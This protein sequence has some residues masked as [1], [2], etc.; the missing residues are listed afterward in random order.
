MD[1]DVSRRVAVIV[2]HPDDEVLWAGGLLLNHPEWS[3]FVAVLT[4]SEDPDRAPRFHRV[5]QR[6]GAAGA[7]GDLDDGPG[8]RP[9]SN[10]ILSEAILALLPERD[11]DIIL[12]HSL[13]GEYTRHRRH[14]ETSR[15]VW[16]LCSQGLLTTRSLCLFA[17]ED[18]QGTY[19]PRA[20]EQATLRLPL[21]DR[22]WREKRNLLTEVYGLA[23]TSW[24]ARTTPREE[25]F[26]C[27]DTPGLAQAAF[28]G[29]AAL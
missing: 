23:E 1:A 13:R 12:T 5:R 24:E 8:Q 2:A 26:R 4:R 15:A 7:M 27:L 11:Y 14:E 29:G 18:G 20:D 28:G 9:L 17:Y 25:A 3:T 22:I 6:L 21:S 19:L 16:S 10:A